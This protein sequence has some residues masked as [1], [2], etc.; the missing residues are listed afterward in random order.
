MNLNKLEFPIGFYERTD[1]F[2][3]K[4]KQG[5]RIRDR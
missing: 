1:K 3:N 5:F 4:Q 2:Q